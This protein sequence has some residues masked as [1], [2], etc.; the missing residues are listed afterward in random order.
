MKKQFRS[1]AIISTIA[2]SFS[3]ASAQINL[4]A[5]SINFRN[6][7]DADHATYHYGDLFLEG[8]A[9]G[10]NRGG[11]R[12]YRIANY[13]DIMAYGCMYIY[14]TKHFVHPH[15]TDSTKLI[16]YIA[17]ESG[18]ALTV[19]RGTAKTENGTAEIE[20]P[21]HFSPVTSE[22]APL[23]VFLTPENA[24]VLL[25]TK[26]KSK[27]NISV[28]MKKSD[29]F[30]FGDVQFAFQVTGVRDGFEDEEIMVDTDKMLKNEREEPKELNPVKKRINDLAKKA[31]K[32]NEKEKKDKK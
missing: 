5:N 15:P 32:I 20:L 10:Y 14:G 26:N 12:C 27:T 22:K 30:E 23:T 4:D 13:G 21:E 28:A 3:I 25:Y 29:L 11:L 9:S 17:I 31:R 1:I 16:K 19:A 7:D 8:G 24:P 6:Y 2:M 18:E